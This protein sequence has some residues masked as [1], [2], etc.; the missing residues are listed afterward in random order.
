MAR[1]EPKQQQSLSDHYP[2]GISKGVSER[3]HPVPQISSEH[4]WPA[5]LLPARAAV[6]LLQPAEEETSLLPCIQTHS[7]LLA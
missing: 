2:E 4:C 3:L 7:L 6:V 1:V 5:W